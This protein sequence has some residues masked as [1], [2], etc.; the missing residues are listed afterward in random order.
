MM[1]F[2]KIW[3]E[4]FKKAFII[5]QALRFK[6]NSLDQTCISSKSLMQIT[7]ITHRVRVIQAF[8]TESFNKAMKLS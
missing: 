1:V 5:L 6:L 4:N 7:Q 8:K 2:L 3:P